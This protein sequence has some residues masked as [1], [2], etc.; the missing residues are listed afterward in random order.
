MFKDSDGKILT[1]S[2]A[3]ESMY[4][5]LSKLSWEPSK[6]IKDVICIIPVTRKP[7]CGSDGQTYANPELVECMARANGG[8]GKPGGDLT[9]AREGKC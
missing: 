8:P 2:Q 9:V 3:I 5:L 6:A 1:K 4:Q 7:V